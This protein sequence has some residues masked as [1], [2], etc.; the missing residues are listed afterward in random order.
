VIKEDF[1]LSGAG[2]E[3][4][5]PL[6][7]ATLPNSQAVWIKG[8]SVKFAGTKED[9]YGVFT[10]NEQGIAKMDLPFVEDTVEVEAAVQPVGKSW[11]AIGIGNPL[12]DIDNCWSGGFMLILNGSGGF[13][14]FAMGTTVSLGAGAEIP[15]F[16]AQGMNTIKMIYHK[17]ENTL[18][19]FV[20]DH[21]ISKEIELG[22]QNINP[23]LSFVGFSSFGQA[24]DIKSVKSFSLKVN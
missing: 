10:T 11:I 20:N 21:L 1:Q 9:S 8:L 16:D 7:G 14:I 23:D 5:E 22:K 13:Q 4:G 15:G 17:K 3:A 18:E 24:P 12:S 2:R 6:E 19:C